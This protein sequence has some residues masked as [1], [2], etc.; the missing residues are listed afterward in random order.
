MSGPDFL[1]DLYTEVENKSW[2]SFDKI[3][4][5]THEQ[6]VELYDKMLLCW[7]MSFLYWRLPGNKALAARLTSDLFTDNSP[8]SLIRR[9]TNPG[10]RERQAGKRRR[11]ARYWSSNMGAV[12]DPLK[13]GPKHF[14]RFLRRDL[15]VVDSRKTG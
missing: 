9:T 7:F 12:A 14:R 8:L 11:R 13:F 6:A 10:R 3:R 15:A 1:E 5:S 2:E 4:E